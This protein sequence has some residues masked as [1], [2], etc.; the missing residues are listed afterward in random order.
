MSFNC[1]KEDKNDKSI[2]EFRKLVSLKMWDDWIL[3][4]EDFF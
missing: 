3:P 2:V 1:P 4:E